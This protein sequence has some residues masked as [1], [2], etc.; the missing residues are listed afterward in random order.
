MGEVPARGVEDLRAEI[1]ELRGTVGALSER[2][3]I[4]DCLHRYSRGLD[5]RDWELMASA[6]HAD[7]VDQHGAFVGS[8]QELVTWAAELFAEWDF[9]VHVLDLNNLEIEGDVAHSECYVLFTQRRRDG[10]GLDFGAGRY[11]DRL[12]RRNGEWRIA[13]R[14]TVIDWSARADVTDLAESSGEHQGTLDRTDPSY[15]R[16]FEVRGPAGAPR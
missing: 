8:P 9:S 10:Q 16:P 13:A 5:R 12:E 11:L 14:Q 4:V 15:R 2:Q 6:Y 7:G 3:A 1:D